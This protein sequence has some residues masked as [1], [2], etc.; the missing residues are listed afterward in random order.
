MELHRTL[1]TIPMEFHRNSMELHMPIF[2]WQNPM[3]ISMAFSTGDVIKNY[4]VYYI[5]E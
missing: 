3:E 1:W 2:L 4:F 5:S